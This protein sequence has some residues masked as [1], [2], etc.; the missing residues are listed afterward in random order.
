MS[1]TLTELAAEVVTQSGKLASGE[2]GLRVAVHVP[3]KS[4]LFRKR[5]KLHSERLIF[6]TAL[7]DLQ[8]HYLAG[9]EALMDLSLKSDTLSRISRDGVDAKAT[10]QLPPGRYRLRQVV[11]E[12][13]GG[14]IATI[15]REVEIRDVSARP[16]LPPVTN[17]LE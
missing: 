4:L 8:N 1:D 15:S 7:F 13:V 6:I 14:R 10:L 17:G 3:G 2:S 5:D 16:L 9:T 11:Q 12:V